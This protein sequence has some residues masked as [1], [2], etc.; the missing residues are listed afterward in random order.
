[1]LPL[2]WKLKCAPVGLG[3]QACECKA[4]QF[5]VFLISS[6]LESFYHLCA[7]SG[8]IV[9]PVVPT[10]RVTP[11]CERLLLQHRILDG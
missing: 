5:E 11:K 6:A 1:M 9:G 2:P 4:N 7:L 3:E 8:L 10:A